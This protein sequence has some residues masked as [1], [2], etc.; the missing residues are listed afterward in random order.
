MFKY[1]LACFFVLSLAAGASAA[2]ED[3]HSANSGKKESSGSNEST[4]DTAKES[5][6]AKPVE[7]AWICP[8][9]DYTGALTKDGKCPECGMKL[10]NVVRNNIIE[11]IWICPMKDYYGP[12]TKD[13]KCPKC[14]MKLELSGTY[15]H[16]NKDETGK[17]LKCAEKMR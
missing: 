11:E 16:L 9:K 17:E 5:A 6:P 3:S 10:E 8:M 7:E 13:G 1:V 14:G 4:A 12:K 15:R 2:G